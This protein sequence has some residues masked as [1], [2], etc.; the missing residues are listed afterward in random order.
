[1]QQIK[2]YINQLEDIDNIVIA[3]DFNQ[4]I[5]INEIRQFFLD[6]G[7]EDVY[8]RI[9]NI[10]ISE[11]DKTYVHRSSSIDSIVVS[12][13]LMKFVKGSKLITYNEILWSGYR[14]FIID[15]NLED[16]FNDKMS[17]WDNINYMILDL[18]RKVII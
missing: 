12:K 4:N 11:L 5:N 1:M 14:T 16:Y 17:S 13:G 2:Q 18:A 8:S 6:I 15:I 3:G 10:W 7:V 9:N